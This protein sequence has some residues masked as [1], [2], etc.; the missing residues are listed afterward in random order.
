MKMRHLDA[1]SLA[2]TAQSSKSWPSRWF[3]M[4]SNRAVMSTNGLPKGRSVVSY[5]IPT[6]LGAGRLAA[7]GIAE[8]GRTAAQRTFGWIPTP[9]G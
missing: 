4:A 5:G 6:N 8:R 9:T 2:K 3:L 7:K 1:R